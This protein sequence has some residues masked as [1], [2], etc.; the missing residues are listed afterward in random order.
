MS[1]SAIL[2]RKRLLVKAVISIAGCGLLLFWVDWVHLR[3]LTAAPNPVWLLFGYIL[4]HL[5]RMLMGLKWR[6]LLH[7]IN[8][9]VSV[10]DAILAFYIGGFWGT[11]LPSTVGSDAV[12]ISWLSYGSRNAAKIFSSVIVE[13]VVGASALGLCAVASL[14]ALT[15]YAEAR[16]LLLWGFVLLLLGATAVLGALL[17]VSSIQ[18]WVTSFFEHLLHDRLAKILQAVRE[19][20]RQFHGQF[21]VLGLFFA[22]S[23]LEQLF[24]I[25]VMWALAR[26]F[27]VELSLLWAAI[28]V[29]I[30]LAV[31]RLPISISGLGVHEGISVFMFSF[32]GLSPSAAI[33]IALAGRILVLLSVAPG[34]FYAAF[35]RGRSVNLVGATQAAAEERESARP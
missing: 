23:A 12:R 22:L 10:I 24:P 31:S 3:Q 35:D 9:K 20:T 34:A 29:P 4:V 14:L 19:A 33:L 16:S 11:F 2:N 1:P 6:L 28:A 21:R 15:L 7:A 5:D 8:I 13:R 27:G 26:A 30:I 17:F 32:A 18:H 25:T